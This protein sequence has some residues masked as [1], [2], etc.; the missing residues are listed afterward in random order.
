MALMICAQASG[1]PV[2]TSTI[3]TT[4]KAT[5]TTHPIDMRRRRCLRLTVS[6]GLPRCDLAL[7]GVKLVIRNGLS[8]LRRLVEPR[9]AI[10]GSFFCVASGLMSTYKVYHELLTFIYLS[11]ISA[12]VILCC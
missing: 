1:F 6:A 11:D 2:A 10:R 4:T 7:L 9:T 8:A 3:T 5:I 12:P